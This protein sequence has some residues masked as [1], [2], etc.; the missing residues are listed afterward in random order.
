MYIPPTQVV[1]PP[2]PHAALKISRLGPGG[3]PEGLERGARSLTAAV[4]AAAA[5]DPDGFRHAT[6][7]ESWA[8]DAKRGP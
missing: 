3:I 6:P 4:H 5:A 8:N 2:G 1:V 7:Y